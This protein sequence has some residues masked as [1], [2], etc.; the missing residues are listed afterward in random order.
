MSNKIEFIKAAFSLQKLP[1]E[2]LPEVILCGRSNVGK[3]SFIN[4]LFN[5]KN[6]AKT[7]SI[8]GKTR[9]LNYYLVGNSYYLVDLPGYGYA[10]VSKEERN[11]WQK[12]ME[13]YFSLGRNILLAV[14]LIDSRHAPTQL[15]KQLNQYLKENS[16]P[17]IVLLNKAD[18]LKQSEFAKAAKEARSVFPELTQGENL[19]FYSALNKTGHKEILDKLS[20]LERAGSDKK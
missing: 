5:R 14:H 12:I 10:K 19:L 2:N 3:S 4:S 17:Y 15:D 18:K 1:P 11:Y 9:S 20:G 8:P 6:L 16:I 7:S 13:G